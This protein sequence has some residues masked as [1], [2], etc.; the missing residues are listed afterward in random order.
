M[1]MVCFMSIIEKGFSELASS[2]SISD[3]QASEG[4]LHLFIPNSKLTPNNGEYD[5]GGLMAVAYGGLNG[6]GFFRQILTMISLAGVA[7]IVP[8][9]IP[10]TLLLTGT[11]CVAAS[12]VSSIPGANKARKNANSE[13]Q[14]LKDGTKETQLIESYT[15][16]LKESG[17]AILTAAN[18]AVE[19]NLTKLL[20]GMIQTDVLNP[21]KEIA[22]ENQKIADLIGNLETLLKDC[23]E[24][25]DEVAFE[26]YLRK[27]ELPK[28]LADIQVE[29]Q[30]KEME[31]T[32]TRE[33]LGLAN[34]MGCFSMG[35][36]QVATGIAG[37]LAFAGVAGAAGAGI[38]TGG[39]LSQG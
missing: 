14:D 12:A 2:H 15:E 27:S 35:S 38:V 32:V 39:V 10:A 5:N 36:G 29:F 6:F 30:T 8:I 4:S 3:G 13:L 25:K 22:S 24:I 9:L 18:Q 33:N 19:V 23:L 1:P 37:A 7:G 31:A 26:T 16:D 20:K 28:L 11:G 34:Q 17:K 21:L